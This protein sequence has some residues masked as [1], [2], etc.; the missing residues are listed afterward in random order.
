MFA[1]EVGGFLLVVFV[2]K[3]NLQFWIEKDRRFTTDTYGHSYCRHTRDPKQKQTKKIGPM[4]LTNVD[5][6]GAVRVN[7]QKSKNKNR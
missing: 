2:F 5:G 4:T 3:M 1:F 7:G 6:Q